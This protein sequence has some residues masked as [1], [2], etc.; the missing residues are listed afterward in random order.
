MTSSMSVAS[1]QAPTRGRP[2]IWRLLATWDGQSWAQVSFGVSDYVFAMCV[3]R[4]ALY[5]GGGFISGLPSAYV[6]A[7]SGTAWTAVPGAGSTCCV[8]R[9]QRRRPV[10]WLGLVVL[11]VLLDRDRLE[12]NGCHHHRRPVLWWQLQR[13]RV[14]AT[15]LPVAAV[16]AG[17]RFT[18]A[19]SGP[20]NYLAYWN[21][22]H[23]VSPGGGTGMND[24]VYS[25]LE[26]KG[27]LYAGGDFDVAFDIENEHIIQSYDGLTSWFSNNLAVDGVGV[28]AIKV[29]PAITPT[30]PPTTS[31]PTPTATTSPSPAA[32]RTHPVSYAL[33]GRGLLRR[34]TQMRRGGSVAPSRKYFGAFRLCAPWDDVACAVLRLFGC[35]SGGSAHLQR[36]SWDL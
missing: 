31:P 22:T 5:V 35:R 13:R 20:C 14:C 21:D 11:T 24:W 18:A 29:F 30:E 6:A 26:H 27:S 1:S 8:V 4:E 23:C 10:L 17:G 36:R 34:L 3:F 28:Y 25:L 32:V 2:N 12:R 15:S 16:Y 7:W 33:L 9:S 19:D